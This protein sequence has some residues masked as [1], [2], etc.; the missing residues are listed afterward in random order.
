MQL[1]AIYRDGQLQFSQPVQFRHQSFRVVVDVPDEE[2]LDDGTEPVCDIPPEVRQRAA[3][4]RERLDRI[5]TQ[6]QPADAEL[7][8]L[9]EKALERIE[10]FKQRE[11]R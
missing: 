9:S 1:E 2:I 10:A 5:R 11:E 4:M 7:P 3:E 8:Q 6:P